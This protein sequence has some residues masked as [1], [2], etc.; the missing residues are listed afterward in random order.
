MALMTL[1]AF[2]NG[3]GKNGTDSCLSGMIYVESY[4]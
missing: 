1:V 4:L 3:T 2:L